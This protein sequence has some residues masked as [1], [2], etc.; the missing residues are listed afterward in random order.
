MTIFDLKEGMEFKEGNTC[1]TK[2]RFY[3][4]YNKANLKGGLFYPDVKEISEDLAKQINS[5]N[6]LTITELETTEIDVNDLKNGYKISY[7]IYFKSYKGS[8]GISVCN[9]V[10]E[11]LRDWT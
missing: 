10:F 5:Y 1:I 9:S 3:L 2:I 7:S 4:N 11:F 6:N 8:D